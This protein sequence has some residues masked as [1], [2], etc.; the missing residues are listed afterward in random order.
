M[1][2]VILAYVDD[3]V[4]TGNDGDENNKLKKKKIQKRSLNLK[5]RI[6]EH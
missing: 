4:V 2:V 5:S 1:N 6:W 3:I